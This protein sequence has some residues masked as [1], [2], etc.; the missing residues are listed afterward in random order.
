MGLLN[1]VFQRLVM[2]DQTYDLAEP[3]PDW[4]PVYAAVREWDA[5]YYAWKKGGMP[6][7][8]TYW[9]SGQ[10][11]RIRIAAGGASQA[12][13]LDGTARDIY[14][15]CCTIRSIPDVM[16]RFSD[17]ADEDEIT[18]LLKG[19]MAVH[20]VYMADGR[21]L[22]LACANKPSEAAAR[23]RRDWNEE[24][25]RRNSKDHPGTGR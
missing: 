23:S 20:L 13:A 4:S 21:V 6:H 14:I 15:Y 10:F 11:L 3:G 1:D 25:R 17:V 9:D 22:A 2:I 16:E 18:S 24:N 12:V 5:T 19:L 8:C 7:P